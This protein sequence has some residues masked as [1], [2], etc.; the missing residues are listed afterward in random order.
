MKGIR[1]ILVTVNNSL[2]NLRQ[3][4]KLAE[5]EKSWLTVLKVLAPYEGEL[6][7]TGIKNLNEVFEGDA[8][9]MTREIKQLAQ[10]E[11]TLI[12]SRFDSGKID[13]TIVK[14]AREERCDLIIMGAQKSGF[15]HRLLGG[16]IVEQV[17]AQAPCP[18]FV[19]GA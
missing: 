7:L 14:V 15:L 11:R 4:V 8:G 18:V 12:K 16:N 17:I 1:K 9:Q 6:N 13:Q 5:E 10:E 2:D 19:V 3:G